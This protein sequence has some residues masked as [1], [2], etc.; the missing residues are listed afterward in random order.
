[1]VALALLNLRVRGLTPMKIISTVVALARLDLRIKGSIPMQVLGN[2]VL[3]LDLAPHLGDL[4]PLINYSIFYFFRCF[5]SNSFHPEASSLPSSEKAQK[6]F[7]S[8][9]KK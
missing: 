3:G 2:N 6:S 9:L 7:Y 5:F 1:M 8:S 4:L